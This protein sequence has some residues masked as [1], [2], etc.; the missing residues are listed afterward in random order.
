MQLLIDI[1]IPVFLIV[2]LG[3][4]CRRSGLLKEGSAQALNQYVFYIAIPPLMFLSTAKVDIET[5]LHWDFIL[6]YVGGSAVAV[7]V[8]FLAW[9]RMKISTPLDWT[10]IALNA[11]WANTV[12]MGVPI[13]YFMFGEKGALPVVISTL[14]S[15]LVFIVILAVVSELQ[16]G[17]RG[18]VQ[19]LR[20][21]LIQALLKNP[22]M[23]APLLGMLVS[24]LGVSL[25][26]A[27]MTPMEMLAPSA[28]PVALFALGISLYGM[29]TK[30]AGFELGWL[31]F[32]K[33]IVHP[34]AVYLLAVW[35]LDLEPFWAAS[36]VLLAALPTGAMVYVLAQQYQTRVT[37]SSATI[38]V[39]TIG[40]IVTLAFLLPWL[41]QW[42]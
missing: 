26:A 36:A 10:V 3:W 33:L 15:N 35:V 28:A 5:V 18:M 37:L 20:A 40:S 30:G 41:K 1:V 14:A 39:T 7:A 11:A 34:L 17:S 29:Q 32:I 4:I 16:S 13:F 6:A 31:T 23:M 22:V 38:M 42:A 21:L 12:Y 27:L 8:A 19:K 2:V 24:V 9:W 25:P